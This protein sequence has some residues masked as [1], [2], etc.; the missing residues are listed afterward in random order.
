MHRRRGRNRH[1]VD[2]EVVLRPTHGYLPGRTA[3]FEVVLRLQVGRV[4]ID[5]VKGRGRCSCRPASKAPPHRR[6][7]HPSPTATYPPLDLAAEYFVRVC[8]APV[9]HFMH[10]RSRQLIQGSVEM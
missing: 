4:L 2:I 5:D 3:W 1:A 6:T 9:L 10:Y 8:A 7:L